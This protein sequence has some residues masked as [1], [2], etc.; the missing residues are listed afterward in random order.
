MRDNRNRVGQFLS[1]QWCD[2][3]RRWQ[4]WRQ[5]WRQRE[6]WYQA[7]AS[8]LVKTQ[9]T[10]QCWRIGRKWRRHLALQRGWF[11]RW[12]RKI[13]LLNRALSV[14]GRLECQRPALALDKAVGAGSGGSI[15]AETPGCSPAIKT[16]SVIVE[17][18]ETSLGGGGGGGGGRIAIFLNTN[19]FA[20]VI[21]AYGGAGFVTGG[22]GTIYI[23]TNNNAFAPKC[24]WITVVRAVRQLH[25]A[26]RES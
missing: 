14:A 25:S 11:W 12:I 26:H 2:H 21:S 23:K 8:T 17:A 15:L 19:L 1:D 7:A 22:A 4:V 20:G 3:G 13:S 24:C 10:A 18:G 6:Q 5:R 9:R 16:I